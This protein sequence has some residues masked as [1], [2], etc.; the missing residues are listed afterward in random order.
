MRKFEATPYPDLFYS[1]FSNALI[2]GV[3]EDGKWNVYLEASN[4]I[5]DQEAEVLLCKALK[6]TADYY[7]THG[8]L[9]WDHKHKVTGDPAFIIGE[10][11]DVAFND[12][13]RTLVKGF[14][15][16]ENKIA[17]GLWDNLRSGAKRLGASVGGGILRK[18]A[19]AARNIGVISK[20]IWDEVALTHKP[21]NDATLGRVSVIPFPEFA[22]ALMAG[23]GVDAGS[24]TGGRALTGEVLQGANQQLEIDADSLKSLFT[25]L[26][27]SIEAREITSMADMTEFILNKGFP[28][29]YAA[30]IIQ[31][32][33]Y[34]I[35]TIHTM[36][37]GK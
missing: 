9:S 21:V 1:P 16:K 29:R 18:A 4:E 31:Y 32:L 25:A 11:T 12:A 20:V 35:P 6:E 23:A 22:K 13:N 37:G 5:K 26:L 8:I 28:P 7:L 30:E 24:F 34:K 14:L 15:Y 36:L 10:P 19:D 17:Q 3:E 27:K 33:V 2:K